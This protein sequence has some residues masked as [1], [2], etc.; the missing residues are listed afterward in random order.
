MLHTILPDVSWYVTIKLEYISLFFGVGLFG[1]YTR[2]LYPDDINMMIVKVI[3]GICILF[4]L[5]VL[6]LP[7]LY[8]TQLMN[9]FLFVALFCL[10]KATDSSQQNNQTNDKYPVFTVRNHNYLPRTTGRLDQS[11]YR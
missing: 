11:L 7:P 1:L 6:V 4:S 8:F 2:Y 9:P 3:S 10:S 5:G